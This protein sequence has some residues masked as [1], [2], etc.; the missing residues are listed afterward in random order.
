MLRE[1]LIFPLLSEPNTKKKGG[2]TA[3]YIEE[4]G[5][6]Q[7]TVEAITLELK[8]M[9]TE[10]LVLCQ[11]K[12]WGLLK[13]G[14]QAALKAS[15]GKTTVKKPPVKKQPLKKPA[16]ATAEKVTIAPVI[17][18]DP[19]QGLPKPK[20]KETPPAQLQDLSE[21]LAGLSGLEDVKRLAVKI[22]TITELYKWLHPEIGDVFA[23]IIDDLE[24]YQEIATLAQ[25]CLSKES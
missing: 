19:M 22:K 14:E 15:Q 24:N 20:A 16:A 10:G 9:K 4:I 12:K 3:G 25:K 1:R 17:I 23:E 8:R 5:E 6:Y 11:A 13:K 21:L 18:G 2:L 7:Y